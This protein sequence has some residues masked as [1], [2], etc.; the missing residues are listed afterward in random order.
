MR[1][2]PVN[3]YMSAESVLPWFRPGKDQSMGLLDHRDVVLIAG[4]DAYAYKGTD[5]LM[6][7]H[8]RANRDGGCAR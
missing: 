8:L 4:E 6:R 3:R 2:A 7:L 1:R 5:D